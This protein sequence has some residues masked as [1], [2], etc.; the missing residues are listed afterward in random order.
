[1]CKKSNTKLYVT[2]TV[3]LTA[4]CNCVISPIWSRILKLDPNTDIPLNNSHHKEII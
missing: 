4:A 1:M 3:L 2:A